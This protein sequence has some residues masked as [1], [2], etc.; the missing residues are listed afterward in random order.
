MGGKIVCLCIWPRPFFAHIKPSFRIYFPKHWCN[1][2]Y[3]GDNY[4][5]IGSVILKWT[6]I[7]VYVIKTGNIQ[8]NK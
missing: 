5:Y 2:F 1:V 8:L 4:M 7:Y 3:I 6:P